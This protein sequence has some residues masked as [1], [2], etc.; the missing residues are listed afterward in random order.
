MN[1]QSGT[2]GRAP[3]FEAVTLI[4][5]PALPGVSDFCSHGCAV[6]SQ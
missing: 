3:A 1:S 6:S 2:F 4:K 5:P